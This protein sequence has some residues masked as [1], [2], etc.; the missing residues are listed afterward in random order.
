[1]KPDLLRLGEF[2]EECLTALAAHFDCHG[3]DAVDAEPSLR[4]RIAGIVTRSDYRIDPAILA[5]LPGLR[6][7]TTSGVGYDG[8]PL[9]AARERGVVVTN[10]PA[11]H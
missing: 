8:I 10:T 11:G 4:A 3:L 2:S 1:M 6:I 9:A 5:G 7:V